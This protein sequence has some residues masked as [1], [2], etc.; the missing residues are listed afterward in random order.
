MGGFGSGRRKTHHI[1]NECL[2][3]DTMQLRKHKLLTN[4][5]LSTGAH[6]K[7]VSQSKSLKEK[8]TEQHHEIYVLVERYGS[9]D[10]SGEFAAWDAIG[11]VT[12]LY[13]VRIGGEDKGG[14]HV[15]IPLVV[16]HPNY[17]GVRYWFLAPCCGSRVR[18]VF[19][20]TLDGS[21]RVLPECRECLRLHYASQQQSYIDRRITY[22]KYLL[23]NA[24]YYW[25]SDEY[26]WG[27]KEHY[28]KV[29][30]EWEYIRQKSILDRELHVLRLLLSSQRVM[31][32]ANIRALLSLKSEEDRYVYV[33]HLAKTHGESYALD[34]VRMLS[35]GAKL[36]RAVREA[37]FEV[38]ANI[39]PALFE[40]L[41]LQEVEADGETPDDMLNLQNLFERKKDLQV[42]LKQLEQV[43]SAA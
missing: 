18:V 31:L 1:T 40:T 16:T 7:Y 14:Q 24:G 2:S 30:P 23:A 43:K 39:P 26:Q 3:I 4:K 29:T 36:E 10:P 27:L 33:E 25:A 17:G 34:L 42:E 37:S 15:D 13:G 11:H 21:V 6:I 32:R 22:E 41:Y 38:H 5:K 35:L 9:G 28:F 8:V 20:P 12:L 19:L